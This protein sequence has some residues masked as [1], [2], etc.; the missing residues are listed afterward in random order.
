MTDRP[1]RIALETARS[2]HG[3]ISSSQAWRA[4]I[5][6]TMAKRRLGDG[7][8]FA[9]SPGIYVVGGAPDTWRQRLWVALL[10]AG[11]GAFVSHRSSSALRTVPGFAPGIVEV[12]KPRAL[13]HTIHHGVLHESGLILPGHLTTVDGI[14]CSSLARTMFELAAVIR[15]D[16]LIR[17]VDNAMAHRGLTSQQLQDIVRDMAKRGR[18]GSAIMRKISEA[19]GAD[20]VPP[21]SGLE[22]ELIDL[23]VG[24]GLPEPER[25]L[26]LGDE[27][28]FIGRVDLGYRR[29]KLLLEVDGGP[30]HT[31]V[32]ARAHDRER[33]NRLTALGFRILNFDEEDIRVH[34]T[35]TVRRVRTA[36]AEA[37]AA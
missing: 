15:G 33:R 14:P 34:T 5:S 11:D 25:Q 16:R 23:L 17:A 27:D 32:S 21:E 22:A 26:S 37:R 19:R 2:Q 35:R 31:S 30:W 8:W 20:Y 1:D 6:P 4:G 3:A 29:Y 24:A 36:L 9:A 7:R 28:S 10:E 12:S 18:T 13:D